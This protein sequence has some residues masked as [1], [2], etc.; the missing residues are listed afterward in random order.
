ML[1][2]H[3]FLVGFLWSCCDQAL[4]VTEEM[5]LSNF[6]GATTSVASS[7]NEDLR[8]SS[9]Q[10]ISTSHLGTLLRFSGWCSWC[11]TLCVCFLEMRWKE[12]L[13]GSTLRTCNLCFFCFSLQGQSV[14][15]PSSVANS[16]T[17]Q[18]AQAYPSLPDPPDQQV[19]SFSFPPGMAA[20]DPVPFS[21]W[22]LNT[23]TN[24]MNGAGEST[25]ENGEGLSGGDMTKAIVSMAS[26]MERTATGPAMD[27]LAKKLKDHFDALRTSKGKVKLTGVT[28]VVTPAH[29]LRHVMMM[30]SKVPFNHEI[31]VPLTY[32]PG[33]DEQLGIHRSPVAP[34]A[35]LPH[36]VGPAQLGIPLFHEC[37]FHGHKD[38][39]S[40]LATIL[41]ACLVTGN[42]SLSILSAEREKQQ[43]DAIRKRLGNQLDSDA[44]EFVNSISSAITPPP[45][46][47]HPQLHPA[48]RQTCEE[49]RRCLAPVGKKLSALGKAW[50]QDA[51]QSFPQAA[52]LTMTK[53]SV[54]M[55]FDQLLAAP[56]LPRYTTDVAAIDEMT[57][58]GTY[59]QLLTLFLMDWVERKGVDPSVLDAAFLPRLAQAWENVAKNQAI[60][61][62]VGARSKEVLREF[63][64]MLKGEDKSEKESSGYGTQRQQ[65][66]KRGDDG[67]VEDFNAMASRLTKCEGA[68][69]AVL[70]HLGVRKESSTQHLVATVSNNGIKGVGG[71]LPNLVRANSDSFELNKEYLD[72]HLRSFRDKLRDTYAEPRDKGHR[73]KGDRDDK[74]KR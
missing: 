67:G 26:A 50:A 55:F 47:T 35:Q 42:Q 14:P 45:Q 6:Q 10:V 29:A 51:A 19:S 40:H 38:I 74:D 39:G 61:A 73:G 54:A 66:P 46:F 15:G 64:R 44:M 21:A 3:L 11:R 48:D 53:Q 4:D 49:F 58:H 70:Q 31:H 63:L 57:L 65:Q 62:G 30:T 2:F 12:L 20:I 52:A 59:G 22:D 68:L 28:A 41:I 36:F 56:N 8:R 69:A 1:R 60:G 13:D 34:A 7:S 43:M 33:T 37:K 27:P 25:S 18:A 23:I 17:H 16:R 32:P 72:G 24:A 71:R 9:T 5:Y